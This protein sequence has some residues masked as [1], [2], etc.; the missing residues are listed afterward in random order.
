MPEEQAIDDALRQAA[1]ALSD[2]SDSPKLDAE[3]LLAQTLDVPRSY[4]FAHPE[5]SLDESTARRFQSLVSRRL[6]GEP[7]AYITGAREFWSLMLMVSPDTLVPRPE[8]EILVQQALDVIPRGKNVS[9]LDLGTGS[10][11]IALAIAKERPDAS[12]TATDVSEN[13]L[14]IARENARQLDIINVEFFQGDWIEPVLGRR[15]DVIVSNPPYIRSADTSLQS[16]TYEPLLALCSGDDG[17]ESIRMLATQCKSVLPE[18][19]H[20]LLEHGFDQQDDVA[21][22]LRSEGWTTIECIRDY[23]GQPRVTHALLSN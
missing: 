8:T 6:R 18:G 5:D 12:V 13:A 20:L 16:L 9:V 11:A 1:A 21:S 23:S 17:L 4:L 3:L 7:L 15:F 22:I 14:R 19:G 10:G 2:A